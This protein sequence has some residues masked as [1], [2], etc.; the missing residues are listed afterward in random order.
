MKKVLALIMCAALALTL[1]ACGSNGDSDVEVTVAPEESAVAGDFG[2]SQPEMPVIDSES[3][4]PPD[5]SPASYSYTTFTL[6]SGFSME[7]PSHWARQPASKSVC[8]T[9]PVAEG[10]VPGRIVVTSKKVESVG[11]ST[12][13]KQLGSY[14]TNILGD[15]DTYEWSDIYTDQPFLGDE[16]AHSVTYS[17]TRD[18]LSYKGYVIL[19][20]VNK[21]IYVYH[22]RCG[23]DAYDSMESIMEYVRDSISLSSD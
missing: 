17:G 8:F 2:D 16:N 14:F 22:F 3:T 13:E 10:T 23:S 4:A 9:E 11:N 5:I 6:E 19:A 20:A 15:F 21:T 7:V 18:G 12:R 1:A